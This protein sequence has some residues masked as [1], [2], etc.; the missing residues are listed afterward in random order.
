MTANMGDFTEGAPADHS[1]DGGLEAVAGQ[2]A[3]RPDAWTIDRFENEIFKPHW[4]LAYGICLRILRNEGQAEAAA[5]ETFLKVFKDPRQDVTN[6][7]AWISRIAART[8]LSE[9]RAQGRRP[10]TTEITPEMR[11]RIPDKRSSA[12]PSFERIDDAILLSE[13]IRQLYIVTPVSQLPLLAAFLSDPDFDRSA[14]AASLE[15]TPRTI[16]EWIRRLREHAVSIFGTL[17]PNHPR[18]KALIDKPRQRAK[19]GP[20]ANT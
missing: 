4:S 1:A 8:S 9:L 5:Q 20:E 6:W 10:R 18:L 13:L 15:V 12:E 11:E 19:R 3:Q 2:T 17:E 16:T 14:V 7:A